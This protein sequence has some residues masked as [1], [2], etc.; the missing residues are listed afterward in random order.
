M[1][2]NG[3]KRKRKETN[4]GDEISRI[5]TDL[6]NVYELFIK[7]GRWDGKEML[8]LENVVKS[9]SADMWWQL[10]IRSIES[11]NYWSDEGC[12]GPWLTNFCQADMS[13][14]LDFARTHIRTVKR[15]IITTTDTLMV[16]GVLITSWETT[17]SRQALDEYL[18]T[19]N[20]D[21]KI[22]YH[23]IVDTWENIGRYVSKDKTDKTSLVLWLKSGIVREGDKMFSIDDHYCATENETENE[24]D[25]DEEKKSVSTPKMW[26]IYSDDC[27][28][29]EITLCAS[30]FGSIRQNLHLPATFTNRMFIYTLSRCVNGATEVMANAVLSDWQDPSWINDDCKE[31][32][33]YA[34]SR[35]LEQC[36][37]FPTALYNTIYEYCYCTLE[38]FLVRW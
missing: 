36:P 7:N 19:V 24:S 3:R 28:V 15:H 12:A 26:Q 20:A 35:T 25:A 4:L 30:K 22:E 21:Q 14:M 5:Q 11:F 16:V 37:F 34:I 29:S 18:A 33:I 8:S 13:A 2:G 1:A 38:R 9:L 23:L 31:L 6:L 10:K 17:D 27:G 32:L